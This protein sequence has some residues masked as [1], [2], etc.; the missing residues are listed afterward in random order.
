MKTKNFLLTGALLIMALFS[1]NGVMAAEPIATQSTANV[2]VTI[3]LNEIL[4]IV[5]ENPTVLLEYTTPDDYNTGSV[6]TSMEEHLTVNSTGPFIVTVKTMTDFVKDED[7]SISKDEVKITATTTDNSPGT[8]STVVLSETAT[9]LITSDKGGF[10]L[11][12]DVN[13]NHKFEEGKAFTKRAG[14]YQADVTYEI[15]AN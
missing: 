8:L 7:N 4:S 5:V 15:T 14:D 6:N 11:K 9:G 2:T 12:Y 3:R 13:Y 10:D 1:V